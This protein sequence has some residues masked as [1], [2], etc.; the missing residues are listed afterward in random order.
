MKKTVPLCCCALLA[1]L[2]FSGCAR[3]DVKN[4]DVPHSQSP[5]P[6][7]EV[8]PAPEVTEQET[9]FDALAGESVL[10]VVILNPT[11]EEL[12][13]A[14]DVDQVYPDQEYG[15]YMLIVPKEAGSTI[16]LE[17]MTYDWD[18]GELVEV[19]EVHKTQGE[20]PVSMLVQQDIPEGYPTLRVVIETDGR[21]GTYDLSYYGKGDGRRDFYVMWERALSSLPNK[22]AMF[23][24][25]T[26]ES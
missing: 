5:T 25:N 14:G 11:Q 10:G 4:T 3:P 8:T 22:L 13:L 7:E 24:A 1:G 20:G 2:L 9:L 18:T 26:K 23:N 15:D 16:T 21:T 12:E 6:S 19:K 17:E